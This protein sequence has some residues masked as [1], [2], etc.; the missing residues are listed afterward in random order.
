[1][2]RSS[3]RLAMAML[4]SIATLV[5][6]RHDA[7]ACGGF[8]VKGRASDV[9]ALEVEQTL[10]LHDPVKQV[11]HFVREVTFR[12]GDT[13]FGFVV[14]TPARPQVAKV[15][16]APFR[17]LEGEYPFRPR[18]GLGGFG[19]GG[20]GAGGAPRGVDVLSVQKLG[21]FTAFV[22]AATDAGGLGQW[23]A[24]NHFE[25]TPASAQWLDHY[26]KLRF[27][28]VA[29]R[30]DPPNKAGVDA[31]A[32]EGA[33]PVSSETMRITFTTPLPFYPYLEPDHPA[34]DASAPRVLGVWLVT[35]APSTPVA[36]VQAPSGGAF[37]WKQP[38]LEGES[39]MADMPALRT[40]L[41]PSLASLL[42]APEK[43]AEGEQP[44]LSVQVFE[45]Q[46]RDRHGYGDVVMVPTTPVKLT[47]AELAQ[48]RIFFDV[49]DPAR[50]DR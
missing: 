34:K 23:L 24:Q 41:G 44:S 8:F 9:P 37:R 42:P 39:T 28:F 40:A 5:L 16:D 20:S 13:S 49:L 25:T 36:A 31:G 45:D 50:G 38:W 14:P 10:I 29:F 47:D 21:S 30:F 2:M 33:A 27:Y 26:V 46:K 17:R 6:A 15:D 22:L 43:A 12:K 35:K 1:M 19:A 32:A 48:R 18:R 3:S 4:A 7:D 11:E